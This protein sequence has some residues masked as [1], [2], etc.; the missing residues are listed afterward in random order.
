MKFAKISVE[1]DPN[2][3]LRGFATDSYCLLGCEIPETEILK[4]PVYQVKI[5]QTELVGIFAAGNSNGIVVPKIIEDDEL[6]QLKKLGINVLVLKTKETALGNL[7]LCNDKG[8]LLPP[9]LKDHKKE[10][11]DA[12]GCEA[13]IATL[14]GLYILG[15]CG[16]ATNKGCLIH[17]DSTEEEAKIVEEIL[18]VKVD[19]G[20]FSGSPFVKSGIIVNSNGVLVGETVTGPE[21]ERIFEVFE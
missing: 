8:A 2:I 3:G 17:R 18:K 14:A 1:G 10:I 21:L 9:I 5:S 20:S 19:V 6:A 7:I 4:A 15:S 12:L 11:E 13:E 16:I